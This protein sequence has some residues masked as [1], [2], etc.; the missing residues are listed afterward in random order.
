MQI[1]ICTNPIKEVE[2][3]RFVSSAKYYNVLYYISL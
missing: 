3:K 1:H 2:Y